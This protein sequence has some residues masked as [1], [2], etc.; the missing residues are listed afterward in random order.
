MN[1]SRPSVHLD[2][3]GETVFR[4]YCWTARKVE[5]KASLSILI[6][7]QSRRPCSPPIVKELVLTG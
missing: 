6:Q 5:N 7:I 3:R 4:D 1:Y 2:R